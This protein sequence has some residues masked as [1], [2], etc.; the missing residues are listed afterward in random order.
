MGP[1]SLLL[2]TLSFRYVCLPSPADSTTCVSITVQA[3]TRTADEDVQPALANSICS[4]KDVSLGVLRRG[5]P[6]RPMGGCTQGSSESLA[7]S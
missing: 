1:L 7:R 4:Q 2:V 5:T 6:G 3:S